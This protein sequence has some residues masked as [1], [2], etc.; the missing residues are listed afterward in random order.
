MRI[1]V[2]G[3][4]PFD[5]EK[6]N[7]SWQVAR[8]LPERI[9]RAEVLRLEVPVAFGRGPRT[10]TQE[11]DRLAP[12]VALCLGQ[13]G[14]RAGITVEFVGINQMDA[15]IPDCDGFQ[16]RGERID[17][18]GPDAFFSTVPVRRMVARMR[19]GG[20]PASVSYTA[21]TYVCND[22]L[23]EVLHHI[24]AAGTGC[25]GGFVHVPYL[26][27]QAAAKSPDTPSMALDHM[28]R[29]VTLG[30]EAAVEAL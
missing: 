9:A 18:A 14:G 21:G 26:P 3:F 15:R 11:I 28:V 2:T 7:P 6:V 4:Q 25:L 12:D 8:R 23:Y 1:L 10:V 24:S 19:E 20:V 29:A 27:E 22:L 5:G 30:L 17:P 16:P 13:A